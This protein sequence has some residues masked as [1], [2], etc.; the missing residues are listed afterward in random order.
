MVT[1]KSTLI[2]MVV[3]MGLLGALSFT[4]VAT[5][6]DCSGSNCTTVHSLQ[7]TCC[8][9]YTSDGLL[10]SYAIAGIRP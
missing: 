2:V 9:R 3:L 1:L 8:D 6:G 10:P 5:L 4:S 7:P